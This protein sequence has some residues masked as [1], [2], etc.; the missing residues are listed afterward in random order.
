M[1]ENR[2]PNIVNYLDSY[3]VGTDELWV[4]MEYLGGT[5]FSVLFVHCSEVP[6]AKFEKYKTGKLLA[7]VFFVLNL[8]LR[9]VLENCASALSA[10]AI[11]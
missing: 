7:T 6:T 2:H 1:K 4:V 11:N 10:S 3:L 8:N 5:F 9:I